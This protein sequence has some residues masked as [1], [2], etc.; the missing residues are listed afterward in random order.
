MDRG[1]AVSLHSLFSLESLRPTHSSSLAV[2]FSP[3]TQVQVTLCT[4]LNFCFYLL[5]ALNS[6]VDVIIDHWMAPRRG[7][8]RQLSDNQ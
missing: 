7:G 3:L 1:V 8:A 6:L 5:S 4:R 2:S